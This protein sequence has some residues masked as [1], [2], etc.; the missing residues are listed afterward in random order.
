MLFDCFDCFFDGML[1]YRGCMIV[2]IIR[3]VFFSYLLKVFW[4]VGMGLVLDLLMG[5]G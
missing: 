4:T 5:V 3:N 2:L 1:F